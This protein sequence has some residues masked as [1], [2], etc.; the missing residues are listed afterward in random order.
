MKIDREYNKDLLR[1]EYI[2]SME[3][4]EGKLLYSPAYIDDTADKGYTVNCLI[5]WF[6]NIL[7]EIEVHGR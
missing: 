1:T 4:K 7:R 6:N 3:T 2:F 5:G